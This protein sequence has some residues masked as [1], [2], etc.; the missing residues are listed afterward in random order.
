MLTKPAAA[1]HRRRSVD[2]GFSLVELAVVLAVVAILSLLAYPGFKAALLKTRRSDAQATLMQLQHRQERWRAQNSRYAS[3]EEIGAPDASPLGHY[4]IQVQAPTA[5]G[6]QLVAV[7][8]GAQA[9]DKPCSVMRIVQAEGNTL[10]TSGEGGPSGG[11]GG[12]ATG[13][14]AP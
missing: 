14:W 6:F 1:T 4:R 2:A 7:A 13:C 3:R 12:S 9:S 8:I 11:V 5:T 10:Y